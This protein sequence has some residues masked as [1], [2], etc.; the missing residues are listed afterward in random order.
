[1]DTGAIRPPVLSAGT[2]PG[3]QGAGTPGFGRAASGAVETPFKRRLAITERFSSEHAL[4][5]AE[6]VLEN[7]D[8]DALRWSDARVWAVRDDLYLLNAFDYWHARCDAAGIDIDWSAI[9]ALTHVL[10]AP[11]PA[12]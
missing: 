3:W 6:F 11:P 2:P 1:M 9:E 4:R 5:R 8:A 12:P 10:D 7:D